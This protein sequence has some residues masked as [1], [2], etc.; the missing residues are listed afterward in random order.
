MKVSLPLAWIA[1]AALLVPAVHAGSSG[2]P[3][4]RDAAGDAPPGL[5]VVAAWWSPAPAPLFTERDVGDTGVSRVDNLLAARHPAGDRLQV[6]VKLTDL[7]T[8][9]PLADSATSYQYRISF[10]PDVLGEEVV[11]V[12]VLNYVNA[13]ASVGILPYYD[14]TGDI[15]RVGLLCGP[16]EDGTQFKAFHAD[17]SMDLVADTLTVVLV[18]RDLD[19]GPGTVFSNLRIQ[20]SASKVNAGTP[21]LKQVVADTTGAGAAYTLN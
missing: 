10:T 21:L 4:L 5:D 3:E 2:S 20:T 15:Q 12:C 17:G 7:T 18:E 13:G 19:V 14:R 16:Q 8:A 6:T 9:Q 1:L 11:I